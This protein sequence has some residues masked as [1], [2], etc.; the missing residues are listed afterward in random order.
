MAA[1]KDKRIFIVEDNAGNLSIATM[2][3][4][5]QGA[6]IK[7]ERYGLDFLQ[8]LTKFMPID[9]ILMDLRSHLERSQVDLETS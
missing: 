1:L 8:I 5:G 4:E 2:Y 7:F 3:L 6:I 9:I